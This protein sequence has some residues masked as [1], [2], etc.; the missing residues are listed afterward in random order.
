MKLFPKSKAFIIAEMAN[1][2]EGNFENAVKIVEAAS[3]AK[4]DAIKF[5]KFYANELLEKDHSKFDHF[6]KLEMDNNKWKKLIKISKDKKLKVFVDVFGIKS[7]KEIKKIGV[8]GI[9]IHSTDINNYELLKF[10]S[11]ESIPILLSTAG[12]YL[13]EVEEALRIIQSTKK[14]IILMHGFQGFPTEIEDLNLHKIS[15]LKKKFCL[16]IGMMDHVS[17][18]SELAFIVPSISL[19]YGASVIEKHITLDRSKKG[20]DYFSALNPNEF[21]KM[22]S[23]IRLS[24]KAIGHESTGISRN[25]M[26]YRKIQKKNTIAKKPIEKNV[27]LKNSLFD[28]KRTEIQ[29]ESVP[30]FEY[31]GKK[32]KKK[33]PKNTILTKS[34]V[35]NLE[36]KIAAVIACR[37]E[38]DRLFAK[39]LQR[40]KEVTIL[41]FLLSQIKKSELIDDIILAISEKSGNEIF[42]EFCQQNNLKYVVGD[43]KDVLK[44]LIDGA[45]YVNANIIFRVTSENP[46]IY[47]EG[48]DDAI[49]KHRNGK[50]DFTYVKD[51]PIGSSFE[52]INLA[53]FEKSHKDGNANHRSELCSL[54]IQENQSKFKINRIQAPK[55]LQYPELRLT[56]DTPQ[57]LLVAKSIYQKLVSNGKPIPLEKVI[58]LLQKN[59]EI[60]LI[61]SKIPLGV[62]KIWD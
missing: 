15:I 12:C 48:I 1:S 31:V 62:T 22:V 49:S 55:N 43:D 5:Q 7:A 11:R 50:F 24:E 6:K 16:S 21:K 54:Y 2:H 32:T 46:F 13:N 8:D 10:Y 45:K 42:V 61:N 41:E 4:A 37:V 27:N 39:P 47:W 52:I 29:N 44:R 51:L 36:N 58:S 9:K 59:P 28:F 18:D 40:I 19:A 25:E 53:A 26:K 30:Y 56:V 23:I 57:D 38:S 17:G 34:M 20:I 33:I 35:Q 14:E 60:T 3:N